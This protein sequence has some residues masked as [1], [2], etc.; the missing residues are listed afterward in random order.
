MLAEW[1]PPVAVRLRR[2]FGQ[3]LALIRTH[4]ILHQASRERDPEGRIV[5]TLDDYAVVRE[6]VLDVISQGIE[7]AVAPIVRDTVKAVRALIAAGKTEVSLREIADALRLDKSAASRRIA[8][9]V[10]AGYLR[11]LEDRKGRPARV[12]LG[13]AMPEE[14]PVLPPAEV[15]HC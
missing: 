2:D 13:E 6:L 12:C 1:I 10:Q 4:A 11:N 15:L 8:S 14:L 9:A 7:V 3:L 5:A